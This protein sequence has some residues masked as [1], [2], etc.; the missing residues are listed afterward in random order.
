MIPNNPLHFEKKPTVS[1]LWK[2]EKKQYR[3]WIFSYLAALVFSLIL[4]TIQVIIL[5]WNNTSQ[6]TGFLPTGGVLSVI[7]LLFSVINFIV[8]VFQSY[9]N[10][11]F[12]LIGQNAFIPTI[13]AHIFSIGIAIYALSDIILPGNDGNK[14]DQGLYDWLTIVT[15]FLLIHSLLLFPFL[16]RQVSKI[17]NEFRISYN[18]EQIEKQMEEIK[19]NPEQYNAF[20]NIFGQFGS[21]SQNSNSTNTTHTTQNSNT[22]DSKEQ[23]NPSSNSQFTNKKEEQIFN[24]VSALSITELYRL[25]EKLEISSYKEMSTKELISIIVKILNSQ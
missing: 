19:K 22:N 1:E 3:L 10:K 12:I 20:M 7:L 17:R 24:K 11:S 15:S 13:L 8:S 5:N 2:N 18:S 25:A 4:I 14:I 16:L 6:K 9:K 23:K 21:F